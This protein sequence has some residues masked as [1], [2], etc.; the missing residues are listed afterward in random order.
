MTPNAPYGGF[1]PQAANFLQQ[2]RFAAFQRQMQEMGN[3]SMQG[4]NRSMQ[5]PAT[6]SGNQTPSTET[7]NN[8]DN[9]N[10]PVST[11][12]PM[13]P[14]NTAKQPNPPAANEN[15][16]SRSNTPNKVLSILYLFAIYE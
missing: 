6:T 10:T 12:A 3:N 13:Q 9:S 7:S 14:N 1:N 4:A 5:Y 8:A 15:N 11:M 2:Q 16:L